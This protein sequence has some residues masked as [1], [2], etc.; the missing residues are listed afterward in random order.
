MAERAIEIDFSYK[1]RVG[2]NLKMKTDDAC[3]REDAIS[4]LRYAI[5][6]LGR[7]ESEAFFAGEGTRPLSVQVGEAIE[8][9]NPDDLHS[10]TGVEVTDDPR[11][12]GRPLL[13]P[14]FGSDG[15]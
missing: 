13:P 6:L 12:G 11:F 2:M 4:I 5:K 9:P 14:R 10:R 8:W 7:T 15:N 1:P 3:T